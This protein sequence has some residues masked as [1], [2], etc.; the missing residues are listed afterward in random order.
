MDRETEKIGRMENKL[1]ERG[2]ADNSEAALKPN[3]TDSA[4]DDLKMGE[5][6]L[7]DGNGDELKYNDLQKS[8]ELLDIGGRALRQHHGGD[9]E[10]KF[11]EGDRFVAGI[12]DELGK[13]F[14]GKVYKA[15]DTTTGRQ[16]AVK[17]EFKNAK[18]GRLLTEIQNYGIIGNHRKYLY[19]SSH[20]DVHILIRFFTQFHLLI[21][22]HFIRWSPSYL[23]RWYIT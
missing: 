7:K 16:V 5:K 6:A 10:L 23:L 8:L 20:Y 14:A 2:S 19:L 11:G 15:T 18:K 17:T 9:G 13:G 22:Y 4:P 12:N 21:L 3:K 1:G